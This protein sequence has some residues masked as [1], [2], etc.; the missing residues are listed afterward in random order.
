MAPSKWQKEEFSMANYRI[1]TD[2][3]ADLTPALIRQ[4]NVTVLPLTFHLENVDYP[5]S[6]LA[7]QK[8][9]KEFYD[10][11][12]AGSTPTTSQVTP[13]AFK[14]TVEPLLQ[15]GEDVLYLAFSSGLSGTY[16]A[17]R[18]AFEELAAAYPQRKLLTVD[19]LAASMGE[20]LL[21]YHACALRDA[22]KPIEEVAQWVTDNR[23]KL[24]HW[25]TVDD[26]VY[27]KRGGRVSGAAAFFGTVL[28]IKPVL[29]VDDEGHLI[30]MEKVRGRRQSLDALVEHMAKSAVE[31]GKQIIFISH[32]DCEADAQY[33]ADAV[34]S[35]FGTKEVYLGNV[36]PVI[37]SHSGPGTVALFFLA[38]NRS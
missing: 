4:L 11:M 8:S 38:E 35:R 37:G 32:G 17:A 18:I 9:S 12:R 33:V 6:V 3:T 25:F 7:P 10:A 23:L 29:H 2:S 34:R 13:E 16:N 20:G 1:L 5:D 14:E 31:P 28:N 26:L 21:V 15:Q 22:D 24:S 27:L 19:T 30:P 36:G